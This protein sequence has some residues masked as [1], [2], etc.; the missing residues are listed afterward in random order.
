[1]AR[2]KRKNRNSKLII[3]LTLLI[4]ALYLRYGEYV[5]NSLAF[6]CALWFICKTSF[7]L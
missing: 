4:L 6:E 7:L 2:R 3:F 5:R 1:M